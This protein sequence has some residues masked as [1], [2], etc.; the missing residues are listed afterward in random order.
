MTHRFKIDAVHEVTSETTYTLHNRRPSCHLSLIDWY[1][2][3][4]ITTQATH[5]SL[6]ASDINK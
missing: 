2:P 4:G 5:R 1:K 6:I 3:N